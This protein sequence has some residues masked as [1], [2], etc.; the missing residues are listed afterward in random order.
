VF[1]GHFYGH[2]LEP[3]RAAFLHEARRVAPELVI[4][5]SALRAGV[6][7]ELWQ[8]R[9]I[10]DGS[11]HRVYKRYFEPDSLAA[12]LGGGVVLYAGRWFVAV[13]SPSPAPASL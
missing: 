1:T 5:Y 12:E 8:E 3:E 10:S 2:L 6:E 13:S 7:P 11:R 4:V 9:E